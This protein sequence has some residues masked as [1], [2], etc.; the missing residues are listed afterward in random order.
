MARKGEAVKLK[1][2]ARKIKS[3]FKI[4]PDFDSILVQENNGK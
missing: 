2:Y 4:Y 3:P 1:N